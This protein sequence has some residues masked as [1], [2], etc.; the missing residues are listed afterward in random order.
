MSEPRNYKIPQSPLG[1]SGP[2]ARPNPGTL[3]VR[4]DLAHIALS[5]RYLAAHYA[6][7]QIQMIGPKES[8]MHLIDRDDSEVLLK[9]EAGTK[10][11]VLDIAGQWLWICLS[12]E[13]PSGYVKKTS[14][15]EA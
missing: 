7:P 13:G 2:V 9:L 4:G 10:V 8:K 6:I 12:P 15:Q 3:P 5:D 14:V 11:E 1:L